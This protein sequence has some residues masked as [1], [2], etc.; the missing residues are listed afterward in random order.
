M[1]LRREP[2]PA[3]VLL[4]EDDA[5]IR[6]SIAEMVRQLG[7]A[8]IEAATAYEALDQLRSQATIGVMITDVGLPGMRG[9]ELATAA[10]KLRPDLVIVLATGYALDPLDLATGLRGD[11][12]I[13]RK[14][15]G[16]DDLRRVLP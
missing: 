11:I 3:T 12:N 4:V 8:V 6:L 16:P 2:A 15:F 1:S 5:L 9:P 7:Y 14:P 13:I 10:R